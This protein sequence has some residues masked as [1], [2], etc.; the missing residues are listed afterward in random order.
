[1]GRLDNG[2]TIFRD[3]LAGDPRTSGVDDNFPNGT[4][5]TDSHLKKNTKST[6]DLLPSSAVFVKKYAVSF[7]GVFYHTAQNVS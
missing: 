6:L 7:S 2:L 5:T 3:I 4:G 1:M